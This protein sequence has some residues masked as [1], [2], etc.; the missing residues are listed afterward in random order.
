MST[1]SQYVR[2]GIT[3]WIHNLKETRLENSGKET[4]KNADLW[5]VSMLR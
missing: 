2:Q 1:D 3:Q 5:N 4:R